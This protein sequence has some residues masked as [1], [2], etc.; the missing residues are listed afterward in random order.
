[1]LIIRKASYL[2]VV[3]TK[4]G[5]DALV[6]G[7]TFHK[8]TDVLQDGYHYKQYHPSTLGKEHYLVETTEGIFLLFSKT[9]TGI[10]P[11]Y[12]AM[13]IIIDKSA[14]KDHHVPRTNTI[15]V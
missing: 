5:T 3:P 7:T 14:L 8:L 13:D 11:L 4:G 10:I 9:E 15:R 2:L 6:E 12:H 1:M